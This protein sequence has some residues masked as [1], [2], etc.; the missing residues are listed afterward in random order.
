MNKNIVLTHIRKTSLKQLILYIVPI[1]IAI[2]IYNVF[3]FSDILN[4]KV[5]NN[6]NEAIAAY[7]EG[8]KFVIIKPEIIYYTGYDMKVKEKS[9]GA[10]YYEI[11]EEDKCNFI[12]LYEATDSVEKSYKYSGI[13]VK[14]GQADGLLDNMMRMFASDIN[15]MYDNLKATSSNIVLQ[16]ADNEMWL[17]YVVYGVLIVVFVYSSAKIISSLVYAIMPILHPAI[18]KVKKFE[19][20][21]KYTDLSE[22][23][24]KQLSEDV[25]HAGGM[26]ITK[27]YFMH[28]GSLYVNIV[29]MSEI[30]F[31]Y[32][33]SQLKDLPGMNFVMYYNFHIYGNKRFKCT[34]PG[35]RKEDADYILDT[36]AS[37]KPDIINGYSEE[38]KKEA[39]KR[40]KEINNTKNEKSSDKEK[41]K[42][43]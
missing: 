39:F 22:E 7:E 9:V 27:D 10:Y 16:Q 1:A 31:V 3:P 41:S 24:D 23:L 36:F 34:C 32:K 19:K 11:T 30:V 35:K 8:N 42:N 6:T 4:P 37:V 40:I 17:Y 14:F 26:Y 43:E 20:F 21:E 15:W 25:T 2:L 33:N 18:R 28:L 29:P 5:V 13:L 12:L 38:N